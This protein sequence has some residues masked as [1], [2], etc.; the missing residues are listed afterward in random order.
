MDQLD[1]KCNPPTTTALVGAAS[2]RL[3]R[4]SNPMS[5]AA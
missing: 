4:K 3:G 2:A 5:D 1:A